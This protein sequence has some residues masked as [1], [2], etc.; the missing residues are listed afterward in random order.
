[1]YKQLLNLRSSLKE[2]EQKIFD[3]VSSISSFEEDDYITQGIVTVFPEMTLITKRL[4]S[5]GDNGEEIWS[6]EGH[7][8]WGN[9]REVILE[10]FEYYNR[11][12][13]DEV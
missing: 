3:Q 5:I 4:W 7:E 2:L 11:I 6:I 1:M 12:K 13:N 10:I 8:F 9:E